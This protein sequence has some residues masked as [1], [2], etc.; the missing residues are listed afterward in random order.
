MAKGARGGPGSGR[1]L[2]TDRWPAPS[3]WRWWLHLGVAHETP[4]MVYEPPL[5]R[6][7]RVMAVARQQ[8]VALGQ[9][10]GRALLPALQQLAAQLGPLGDAL[11]GKPPDS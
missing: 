2:G 8:Y 6:L 3:T 9:A 4:R 1:R 5:V 7:V 11:V 10:I